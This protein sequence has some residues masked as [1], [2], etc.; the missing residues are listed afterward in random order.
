MKFILFIQIFVLG[1]FASRSALSNDLVFSA[2]W[3][4]DGRIL[5]PGNLA[6]SVTGFVTLSQSS[7]SNDPRIYV[8]SGFSG[9]ELALV[10]RGGAR[11]I[12]CRPEICQNTMALPRGIIGSMML[13]P[14]SDFGAQLR[15]VFLAP[16]EGSRFSHMLVVNPTIEETARN[17]CLD[18]DFEW[19]ATNDELQVPASVSLM[20]GGREEYRD[21]FIDYQVSLS[22]ETYVSEDIMNYIEDATMEHGCSPEVYHLLPTL[23]FNFET[24][25]LMLLPEDWVRREDDGN[26]VY[27][28]SETASED[29]LVIGR[30]MLRN[31][32]VLF[33]YENLRI[34]FCEPQ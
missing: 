2:H 25:N 28:V 21:D 29:F 7:F 1:G 18:G 19:V 4:Q 23:R 33:D 15:G 6:G 3:R 11:V 13:G 30:D 27:L 16:I 34:G 24:A 8:R 22:D 20:L 31:A 26:C 12:V 9:A 17:Y 14:T 10:T 32:G 5:V